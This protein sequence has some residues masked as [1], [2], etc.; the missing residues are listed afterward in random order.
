[1]KFKKYHLVDNFVNLVLPRI[2]EACGTALFKHEHVLC[3]PCEYKLPYTNFH[4]NRNN[5]VEQLFWGKAELHS[6][7]ALLKYQSG[8]RVQKLIHK[9]KY[10]RKAEIGEFLGSKLGEYLLV[11]PAFNDIDFIIPVPLHPQKLKLRGYNQSEKIGLGIEK[12][13]NKKLL[14]NALKR[15]VHTSSQTKKGRYERWVNVENIFQVVNENQLKNSK[16]L[17]VDDVVT[18]GSTLESCIFTLNKI[19]GVRISIATLAHTSV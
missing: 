8:E 15:R 14:P 2:C 5:A 19:E 3:R 17:I 7:T 6:A 12:A 13:M 1:M 4:L 10:K 18:T 16:V 11:S 9:L